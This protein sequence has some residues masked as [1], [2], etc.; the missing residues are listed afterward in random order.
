MR[1]CRH[2]SNNM[3]LVEAD[4]HVALRF[5]V[6]EGSMPFSPKLLPCRNTPTRPPMT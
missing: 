5:A 6:P 1:S 3:V 4:T 2:N